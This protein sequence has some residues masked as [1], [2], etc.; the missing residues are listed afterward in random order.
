VKEFF[1]K[2]SGKFIPLKKISKDLFQGYKYLSTDPVN[3]RGLQV[4][5]ISEYALLLFL[6]MY[7]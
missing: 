3:V 2:R 5:F 7:S 1:K 4:I 6:A